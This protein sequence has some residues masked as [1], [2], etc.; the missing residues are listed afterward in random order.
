MRISL[1]DNDNATKTAN[2]I[3]DSMTFFRLAFVSDLVG[4]VIFVFL[5]LTLYVLFRPVNEQM[6]RFFAFFAILSVP[7]VMLNML[8]HYVVIEL[9]SG[10]AYLDV[11]TPA[12]INTQVLFRLKMHE[13]G[14]FI[15][16]LWFGIWL[17]PLGIVVNESDYFPKFLAYGL[18]LASLGYLIDFFTVFLFPSLAS[19]SAIFSLFA[20]LGEIVFVLW[21]VIKGPSL[22]EMKS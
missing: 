11:Y 10:D 13:T 15:A 5:A 20:G 16:Q 2:D 18:M 8:N 9:L 1:T 17:L 21:M 3:S 14:Y 19:I 6:S 4:Q 7:I 12:E 22:P